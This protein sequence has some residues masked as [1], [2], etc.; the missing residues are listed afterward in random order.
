MRVC[1]PE[2]PVL[3][4]E[5][6]R[7]RR[8]FVDAQWRSSRSVDRGS[9][10]PVVRMTSAM[11]PHSGAGSPNRP[12][13]ASRFPGSSWWRAAE[14]SSAISILRSIGRARGHRP[15]IK[16]EPANPRDLLHLQ[17]HLGPGFQRWLVE[18]AD[19]PQSPGPLGLPTGRQGQAVSLGCRRVRWE[20]IP[21]PRAGVCD[22]RSRGQSSAV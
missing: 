2:A 4:R 13:G 16:L 5:S 18:P 19:Q 17:H 11:T 1:S 12:E 7:R 8:H 9:R 3:E 22:V 15:S 6:E 14:L 10:G 20:Y 21:S